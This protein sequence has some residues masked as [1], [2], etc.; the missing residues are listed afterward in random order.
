[1]NFF[2]LMIEAFGVAVSL[3]VDTFV[4]SFAY[5][6]NKIKIPFK[7]AIIINI[8]CAI[9][10][11]LSVFLGKVFAEFINESVASW[12]SFGALTLIGLLK[13]LDPLIKKLIA[14]I[15]EKHSNK[16]LKVVHDNTS[17]D[18]NQNKILSPLE[19]ISLALALCIDSLAVGFSATISSGLS[20]QL[21]LA[22][23][24]T[25]FAAIN[26]GSLIGRKVFKNV[27]LNL[28][29]LSGVILIV[30]AATRLILHFI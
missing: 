26:L 3:S 13:V 5:G 23:F 20:W 17:A 6:V 16:F 18:A 7:S 9:T 29:W 14:K 15:S 25:D 4:C 22:A 1:M 11:A 30:L 8:I 21:V 27:K 10:M 28:D 24:I 12:I 19:A 2:L